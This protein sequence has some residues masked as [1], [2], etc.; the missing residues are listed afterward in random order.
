MRRFRD[1]LFHPVKR[2]KLSYQDFRNCARWPDY[3]AAIEDM[4][5]ETATDHAPWYPIPAN[6]KPYGR[7]AAFRILAD[8]LGKDI[9]L[10]PSPID[11]DLLLEA[12]QTL[13][14]STS[15]IE[16]ASHRVSRRQT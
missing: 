4:I 10:E 13:D 1:R 8:R 5:E 9:S 6:N 3:E 12:K 11:P 2:W 14:L 16:R 7:I 15:D